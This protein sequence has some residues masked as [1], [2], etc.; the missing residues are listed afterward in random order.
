MIGVILFHVF[1]IYIYR[2]EQLK[3]GLV[4]T[5]SEGFVLYESTFR[6][7]ELQFTLN[8]PVNRVRKLS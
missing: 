6:S 3:I 2:G 4:E 5:D 8:T 7:K 1:L